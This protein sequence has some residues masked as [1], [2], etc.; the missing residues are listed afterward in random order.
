[1]E[2]PVRLFIAIE[3]SDEA[4]RDLSALQSSLMRAGADVKWV[5]AT[6]IHLTL[7]FLGDCGERII[8]SVKAALAAAASVSRPFVMNM[9]GIGAFPKLSSPKIIWVGVDAGA[10]ESAA[11][12]AAISSRLTELGIPD[13]ERKFSPHV[14]LGRV[15][16]IYGKNAY[17]LRKALEMSS[18]S[19]SSRTL[20]DRVVLCSSRLSPGGP[21]YTH[22]SEAVL[23]LP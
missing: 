8:P 15:R 12:A 3:L 5:E 2:D 14:T 22:L 17:E 7:R 6:N 20:V 21:T 1:M 23:R 10:S 4:R 9:K 11:L 16:N 19:A 13:E 18:F